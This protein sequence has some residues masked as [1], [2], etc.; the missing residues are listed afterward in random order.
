[1]EIKKIKKISSFALLF[2]IFASSGCLNSASW[3]RESGEH[4]SLELP[5]INS[6]AD[7]DT[8][9]DSLID[10]DEAK[11]FHEKSQPKFHFPS[12]WVLL[13]ILLL[14]ILFCLFTPGTFFY[15]KDKIFNPIRSLINKTIRRRS[16]KS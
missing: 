3:L 10:R 14:C 11:I 16:E 8:N 2:F 15:L 12:H 6:F 4:S 1:M 7:A 13:S 9:K 5:H